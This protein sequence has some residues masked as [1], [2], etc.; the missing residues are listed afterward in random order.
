MLAFSF[1]RK[2]ISIVYIKYFEN[3]YL[4]LRKF[5]LCVTRETFDDGSKN[6]TCVYFRDSLAGPC[7]IIANESYYFRQIVINGRVAFAV[8]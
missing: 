8:N 1:G 3:I 4:I 2:N 5:V 7:H 6:E